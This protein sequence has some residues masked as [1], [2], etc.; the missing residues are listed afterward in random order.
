MRVLTICD[1]N[2]V[3]EFYRTLTP[4]RLLAEAGLIE[5]EHDSGQNPAI[6]GRLDEFQAVV[7]SRPDSAEHGLILAEAKRRGLRTVVDVDDNLFLLPPSIG[8]YHAWHVRGSGAITPRLWYHKYCIKQA[9]VLTVSTERLGQQLCGGEPLRLRADY[10]TLPNQVLA[11]EW[12]SPHPFRVSW[13][14]APL[15]L[16]E[17]SI[18]KAPGEK[19]VGW[20]GI[21]NHWDDW[22]EVAP[23][24]ETAIA[25][26]PEVRLVLLG[27]PELAHLFPRLRQSS[28]LILGP[29]AP[30]G[31][32]G[33]Y[34]E[35]LK[36]FDIALAPTCACPFNEAKSD[37]KLLQYGAAGVA[38]I[39][40]AVTYGDWHKETA[41]IPSGRPDLWGNMLTDLL[42]SPT[43]AELW[44]QRLQER[45]LA[46]RTY[47]GNYRRWLAALKG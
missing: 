45:V 22:R 47:E 19:W 3:S 1:E 29:F 27:M 4:Y 21:Y 9:E 8:V 39:A 31:E 23:A 10:L 26:R 41:I 42:D 33:P 20:W 12:T 43:A 24:V 11:S 18:T 36:Q 6:I 35:L 17:G 7:F 2:G 40:S 15:L 16:G 13:G 14:P 28:Q 46:T 30:P 32:I 44:G 25:A 37:L 5:L 38:A 34:R